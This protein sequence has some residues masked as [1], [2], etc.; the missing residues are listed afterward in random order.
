MPKKDKC[1]F[2][3]KHKN[4]SPEDTI[5]FEQTLEY[6]NHIADKEKSKQLFLEDQNISKLSG[7]TSLCLSFDLQKVLNTSHGK[8]VTL[9]YSRKYAYYNESIYESGT[10]AGYCYLWGE[11]QG[12]RG[13]NEIVT[14]IYKYLTMLDNAGNHRV[15]HLYADSCAGQN[16]NRAMISM[17]YYFLKIAIM[18]NNIK[19]TY[20]LPGHTMMPVDSIHS[21]IERFIR[22]KTV[23]APSEWPTMI[24]NARSNPTGYTV[25]V[26]NCTD[27]MDW[28]SFSLVLLPAKYKITFNSL[29]IVYLQ[30]QNPV[31]TLQ[32]GF[33]EDS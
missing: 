17:L 7:S 22:H 28:K 10:K 16:R 31:I 25:N 32:Y 21:T 18:I 30:K 26:L 6:K 15:I 12:K 29:K 2:C 14:V 20:L 9:F 3:E 1:I 11:S 13:C 23:W 27:F 4:M 8:S 5:V 19:V 33:F 24:T